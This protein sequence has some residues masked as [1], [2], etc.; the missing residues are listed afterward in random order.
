MMRRRHV[1][2]S[3]ENLDNETIFSLSTIIVR[4]LNSTHDSPFWKMELVAFYRV[5]CVLQNLWSK[6]QFLHALAADR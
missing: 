5:S 4:L 3:D 6:V 2:F 1:T